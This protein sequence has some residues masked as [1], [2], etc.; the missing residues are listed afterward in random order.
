M[1]ICLNTRL[2]ENFKYRIFY[3]DFFMRGNLKISDTNTKDQM[4]CIG[5]MS[6]GLDLTKNPPLCAVQKF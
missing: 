6:E 5:R 3:L 2:V 1:E 4:F